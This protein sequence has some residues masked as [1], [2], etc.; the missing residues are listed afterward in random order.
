[1]FGKI[2]KSVFVKCVLIICLLIN[3]LIGGY[4]RVD[5]ADNCITLSKS[6][7][8]A[9]LNYLNE[10]YLGKAPDL[11]LKQQYGSDSDK[12]IIADLSKEIVKSETTN[13]GKVNA[14]LNW[15]HN[16]VKYDADYE[17][18]NPTTDFP[19]D[20]YYER[21]T[22]AGGYA[23]MVKA[24]LRCAGIP[25]VV[26]YGYC[27]DM[28]SC[29]INGLGGDK[30]H[31]WVCAYY[32]SKWHILNYESENWI[33]EQTDWYK[34]Y[35]TEHVEGVIPH[36][37]GI[38]KT[39]FHMQGSV[40]YYEN[41]HYMF[42]DGSIYTDYGMHLITTERE[43]EYG[44]LSTGET[45]DGLKAGEVYTN[46]WYADSYLNANGTADC[47]TILKK[48]GKD[49]IFMN[50][51][52]KAV[53]SGKNEYQMYH[54][55]LYLEIGESVNFSS[56][57]YSEVDE[58]TTEAY[59]SENSKI[60]K[61]DSN[62]KIVAVSEGK[63]MISYEKAYVYGGRMDFANIYIYVGNGPR[64]VKK[65]SE[66]PNQ[67]PSDNPPVD[68][69]SDEPSDNPPVDDPSDKPSDNPSV[70]DPNEKNDSTAPVFK[71][72]SEYNN[73]V[74]DGFELIITDENLA[75]IK[76]NSVN[77][78]VSGNEFKK[79]LSAENGVRDYKIEAVDVN[80]NKTEMVIYVLAEWAR[81][82]GTPPMDTKMYLSAEYGYGGI[83]GKWSVSGDNT[84]YSSEWG[85]TVVK[86]GY[87][88][89]HKE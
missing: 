58:N 17:L 46:C 40:R 88:T 7:T 68:D 81:T 14:I 50:G 25:A 35:M 54:N 56:I 42:L 47:S 73:S 55:C 8:T 48:D 49:I 12:K 80:G 30:E 11:A 29:T 13:S 38:E 69:P 32:D 75:S 26:A 64:T 71:N 37:E 52:N 28:D 3:T 77:Q 74:A 72:V 23:Q 9:T 65:W 45:R 60:A 2:R 18:G 6:N 33:V 57:N 76:I 4:E 59:T 53:I 86:S 20:V 82:T 10:F 16:N 79:K 67:K 70:D 51:N 85:F 83:T 27:A 62:G 66:N 34:N 44:F 41:T 31:A 84:I 36:F 22:Y 21:V 78:T 61:V 87:Y 89:F 19:I 43:V 63:V 24:L 39:N 1:M 15:M 5:A